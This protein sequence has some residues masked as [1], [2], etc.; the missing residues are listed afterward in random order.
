[1]SLPEENSPIVEEPDDDDCILIEENIETII[2]PDDEPN[3]VPANDTNKFSHTKL[4][5]CSIYFDK[6]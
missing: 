6:I 5:K 1:M 2:I 4:Y 3:T